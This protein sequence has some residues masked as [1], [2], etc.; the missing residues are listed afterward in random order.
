[1]SQLTQIQSVKRSNPKA[2]KVFIYHKD[3]GKTDCLPFR[4]GDIVRVTN[5]GE[6]YSNYRNAFF[7]FTNSSDKPYYSCDDLYIEK[8]RRREDGDKQL[9]KIIKIA[10]HEYSSEG[11]VC[12]IQ[13]RAKRGVVIGPKGLKLVKQFPLRKN[14]TIN[15]V[16]EKIK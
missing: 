5:W 13:D 2:K 15:I 10:E 6:S 4:V 9:F 8:R 3:G 12:Y 14:E 1:M 11:I 16:L 7:Y